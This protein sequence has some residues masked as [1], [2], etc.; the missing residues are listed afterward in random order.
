M[1]GIRHITAVRKQSLV[2]MAQ[3]PVASHEE[4]QLQRTY[5]ST[6]DSWMCQLVIVDA[7]RP[8]EK[9]VPDKKT[10]DPH[11]TFPQQ[12]AL[13]LSW[14]GVQLLHAILNLLP[15]RHFSWLILL[16]CETFTMH[17]LPHVLHPCF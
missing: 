2:Q 5:H 15:P 14:R 9:R 13:L 8:D 4:C 16:P 1:F 10:R 3:R 17:T 12:R 11:V 7:N 6:A